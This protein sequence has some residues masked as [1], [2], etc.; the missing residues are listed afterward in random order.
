ML[1]A[2]LDRKYSGNPGEAFFTAGGL[3]HFENF[4]PSEDSQNFTVAQGF[5]HSVNLVFIRLMRDI[6]RYYMYRVPGADPRRT[7]RSESAGLVKRYLDRFAD[8]EGGTF[9]R[10]FFK[11]YEGQTPDQSLQTLTASIRLTPLRAAVIF[12][13]VRPQAG[14]GRIHYIHAGAPARRGAGKTGHAGVVYKIW[15]GQV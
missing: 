8:F 7:E 12:R 10:R 9:L 3:H 4:E 15:P 5:Q 2:A 14:F 11:K 6:E 13:S 1:E